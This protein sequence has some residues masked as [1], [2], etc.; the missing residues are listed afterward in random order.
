MDSNFLIGL[1]IIFIVILIDCCHYIKFRH[2]KNIIIIQNNKI[3]LKIKNNKN[4]WI[5]H[6]LE[7][8]WGQFV[9]LEN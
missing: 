3:N 5:L 8:D 4:D 2:N 1:F 7:N 6:D 9:K